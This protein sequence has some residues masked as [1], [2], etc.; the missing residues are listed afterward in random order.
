M[1]FSLLNSEETIAKLV[2][3]IRDAKQTVF[4]VSPYV[5]M[6]AEDRIGR[7][8]RE[9]L[10]RGVKVVLVTREDEQTPLKRSAEILAPL[11]EQGLGWGTVPGLH[12]KLYFSE[13]AV[14]VTSL[15]LL[16][17]SFLNTIEIGLLSTDNEARESVARFFTKDIW[18]YVHAPGT[19]LPLAKWEEQETKRAGK[20]PATSRNSVRS[21]RRQRPQGHCIRCR[22][23]IPLNAEKP[24]CTDCF[25]EWAQWENEDYRD[26]HCH[27]CGDD[28]R[29]SMRRPLCRDCFDSTGDNEI[30]F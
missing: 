29:A 5:T 15:N 6:G 18:P 30:P 20:V 25:E 21:E 24:Y 17:S 22:E 7:A 10:S 2:T 1:N 3:L 12:A 19:G 27:A 14:L 13:S 4:L 11:L 8:V 26:N 16:A 9:A 23:G 28:Y